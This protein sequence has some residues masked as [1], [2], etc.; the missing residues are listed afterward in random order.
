MKNTISIIWQSSLIALLC[1]A[2]I[3]TTACNQFS[4]DTVLSDIDLVLQTGNVVCS[5]IGVVLPADSAGCSAVASLGITGVNAIKTAYD[6]YKASGAVT[7]LAKL[8][9]ALAAIQTNLPAEL[10]AAHI[11][12]PAA[13]QV[14]TAWV[15]LVTST[16]GDIVALVPE[17]QANAS[18]ANLSHA[19]IGAR[20][21]VIQSAFPTPESLKAKWETNVCK[22]DKAC[23]DRVSVHHVHGKVVHVLTF[24]LVK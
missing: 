1:L 20:A 15:G 2:M 8:Q 16:V 3:S 24:T 13:V 18:T 10:A 5:S 9:A 22:G 23:A 14:V 6:S 21:T 11:S 12:D 19:R 17:L 7:D 4:V